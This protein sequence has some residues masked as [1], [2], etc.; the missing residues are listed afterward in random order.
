[1]PSYGTGLTSRGET[2]TL[3]KLMGTVDRSPFAVSLHR[4]SRAFGLVPAISRLSIQVERGDSVLIRGPNGAGKST[5]L[6][7]VA[8]AL[9]NLDN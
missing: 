1:M 9:L 2:G 3:L 8:T 5:L 6:R 7:I 4:L